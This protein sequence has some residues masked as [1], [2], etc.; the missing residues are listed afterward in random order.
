MKD[1]RTG[2]ENRLKSGNQRRRYLLP[3]IVVF[4]G[5]CTAG[6]I[7]AKYRTDQQK[8]AEAI[9]A[10]FHFTSDLLE[11]DGAEYTLTDWSDGFDIELYNYEKE[12]TALISGED[13]TYSVQLSDNQS[14]YC[15]DNNQGKF[16]KDSSSGKAKSQ[17]IHIQP[18]AGAKEGSQ[19]TVT[20]KSKSPFEKTLSAT[21]TMSGSKTPSYTIVDQ[22]DGTVL[23]TI[24]TN[25]YSGDINV[26][27]NKNKFD[28]DNTNEYMTAWK[29]SEAN[30]TL[31]AASNTTYSLLFFKNTTENVTKRTGSGAAISLP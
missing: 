26:S 21:F 2:K 1:C 12:N 5:I 22:N 16:E 18:Q 23:L 29:D 11:E 24:Q 9:A 25:S 8:Q 6:G 27:W 17:T 30:G 19:V 10:E 7:A 13:I 14:W 3:L 4:I 31:K 20:V 28:P 15:N